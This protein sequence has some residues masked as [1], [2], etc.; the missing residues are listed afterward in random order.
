VPAD[1]V[2]TDAVFSQGISSPALCKA[3]KHLLSPENRTKNRHC[4]LCNRE[5]DR[6][7]YRRT[8]VLK[9]G[10]SCPRWNGTVVHLFELK[11]IRIE[12][13]HWIWQ[14][15]INKVTNRP[16]MSWNGQYENPA[17]LIWT[18]AGNPIIPRGHVLSRDLT[19]CN[20]QL[21]VHPA[22]H[23]V[24][25]RG[26]NLTPEVRKKGPQTLRLRW[27]AVDLNC[28]IAKRIRRDDTG[29]W[30]WVGSF[31]RK[32][33]QLPRA[34]FCFRGNKI[35]IRTYLWERAQAKIPVTHFLQHIDKSCSSPDEC[36]NPKHLSLQ[37]RREFGTSVGGRSRGRR[38]KLPV[39]AGQQ[40]PGTLWEPEADMNC[41]RC[42]RGF[43]Y[44][45][46]PEL[47]A[48]KLGIPSNRRHQV[49]L[50][51]KIEMKIG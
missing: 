35:G 1:R 4:R 43:D 48:T 13:G 24:L 33:N 41:K 25:K 8:R 18:S 11:R 16:L 30:R 5:H 29:C 39:I 31:S 50:P 10:K 7:R 15:T 42:R 36:V 46:V 27:A 9:S 23:H 17:R 40:W 3:G 28:E 38:P 6:E 45:G 2:V 49:C 34:V 51:V 26:A 14:H 37:D 47:V 19:R 12:Y 20:Q 44:H 32:Q 21:C 22:H